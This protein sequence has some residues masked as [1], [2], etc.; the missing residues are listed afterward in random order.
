VLKN[1]AHKEP[2]G[3]VLPRKQ[4][5]PL[6]IRTFRNKIR[7]YYHKHG[8]DLPWR[9]TLNPYRVL[10]SEI[11]LQQTQVERVIKKYKEFLAAFPNFASLADA[12]VR[13]L[14]AAWQGMGYN[15][16]ALALQALAKQVT[17]EYNSRLPSDPA[18]LIMLPGIGKYTAGA[19]AAF[20]FNKPVIFLD[21]NIRR[22][23]I[24]EFFQNKENIKDEDIYPLLEKT[25][26]RKAPRIWYNALMDYGSMLKL[27][28]ANPNRKSAHYTRQS[29][30]ENSNRQVRGIIIKVL[31]K[32]PPLTQTQI[33]GKT[34]V[35]ASRV[36]YNL[37]RLHAEGFV[38]KKG[39]TFFI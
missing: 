27:N 14:L 22:V 9:K 31:V 19:V 5:T 35:D 11:M 2:A 24:H 21:T 25:L 18:H 17:T 23:F 29:P 16:R 33:A 39:K 34:G 8:R 30:F 6:Q 36:K 26:D 12:P 3:T 32:E 20:A 1:Q 7:G 38:R 28:Q 10:V 13:K 4:L 15:R 37:A